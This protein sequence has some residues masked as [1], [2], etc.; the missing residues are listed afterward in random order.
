[1]GWG[2]CRVRAMNTSVGLRLLGIVVVVG[3]LGGGC[4]SRPKST[5]EA[6]AGKVVVQELVKST[7]SW[8]G[9]TLPP[10]PRGQPEITIKRVIIPVG[11]RLEPHR[12]PVI[13]A[14]V[15]VRGHLTVKAANGKSVDVKAGDPLVELVDTVHYGINTGTEP[16]E[17]VVIYAG[18]TNQPVMIK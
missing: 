18:T 1:M 11:G 3:L 12:H 16:A 2:W 8:D 9:A 10:Y 14:G 6:A 15:L 4:V 7:T 13:N 5:P 17:I